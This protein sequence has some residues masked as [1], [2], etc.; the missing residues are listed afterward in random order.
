MRIPVVEVGVPYGDRSDLKVN[1][2]QR[3][4]S[5]GPSAFRVATDSQ[6]NTWVH[7]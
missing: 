1:A 2:R 4:R 5:L 3:R 7:H 6:T